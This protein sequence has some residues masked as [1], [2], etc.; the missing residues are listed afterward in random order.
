MEP[1][2]SKS[3]LNRVRGMPFAWSLNPYRGCAHACVYCF[4]RRTHTYLDLDAG[5]DF[6]TRIFAKVNVAQVLEA[7]L[8]SPRWRREMVAVGTATDPY[9]PLE[10]RLQLTRACLEA[11]ARH[12][13]PATIVTKGPMVR[14]DTDVLRD[15]CRRA[16]CT[17]CVSIPT[18]DEG[19]WRE[20]EPG[21]AAP[22]H[23]LL[24]VRHLAAAGIRTGVLLAPLLPGL[25]DGRDQIA[26]TVRAAAA[27]C[28]CFVDAN[29]L[30]LKPEVKAYYYTFLRSQHPELLPRYGRLY[31]GAYAPADAQAAAHRGVAAMAE[32]FGVADRR[33]E[34][35]APPARPVAVP[36]AGVGAEA[37]AKRRWE[38]P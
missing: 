9:Q 25:T 29:L 26:A 24:A 15:L 19:L 37:A 18:V 31:P 5:L 11:L 14:R 36:L 13:T 16:G 12:R 3:A 33:A 28:A 10:G 22:R 35:L 17:V 1:L 23:R 6:S 32:R 7:E 8:A 21:T 34:P 4:A 38:G 20:T 27:H 30:Y 2:W